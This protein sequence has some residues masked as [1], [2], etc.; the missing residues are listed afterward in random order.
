MQM[1]GNREASMA[2]YKVGFDKNGKIKA[3]DLTVYTNWGTPDTIQGAVS[4]MIE[5][6]WYN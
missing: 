6:E 3:L 4:K 5:L 1:T 2:Q